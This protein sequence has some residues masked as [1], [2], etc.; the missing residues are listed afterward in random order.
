VPL[1]KRSHLSERYRGS[2]GSG[3]EQGERKKQPSKRKVMILQA[4]GARFSTGGALKIIIFGDEGGNLGT[5]GKLIK[6]N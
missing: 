5:S 2:R 3:E 4:N 6:R 1:V